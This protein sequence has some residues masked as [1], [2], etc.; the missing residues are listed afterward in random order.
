MRRHIGIELHKDDMKR[1]Y[2]SSGLS[3]EHVMVRVRHELESPMKLIAEHM[4]PEELVKMTTRTT[5]ISI[6]ITTYED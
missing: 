5:R 6:D 4:T 2:E 1:V 3:L